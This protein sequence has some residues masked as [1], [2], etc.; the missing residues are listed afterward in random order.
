MLRTVEAMN[1][2]MA[3]LPSGTPTIFV[4]SDST[5]ETAKMLISRLLVQFEDIQPVVR[6]FG[7]VSSPERLAEVLEEASG[8]DSALV[9]ATLVDPTMVGWLG[10][11]GREKSLPIVNV[12]TPLLDQLSEFLEEEAANVPGMGGVS[13]QRIDGLVSK[14][15]FRMVE[16]TQFVQETSFGRNRIS[17]DQ[18]DFAL[19]GLRKVGKTGVAVN[20]AQRG[21][22]AACIQISKD[23]ELKKELKTFGKVVVLTMSDNELGLRRENYIL[24]LKRK[25]LPLLVEGVKSDQATIAE[26]RKYLE[27][28]VRAHPN[29]LGPIDCTQKDEA[30]IVSEILRLSR[31]AENEGSTASTSF[32]LELALVPVLAAAAAMTVMHA[33]PARRAARAPG[34]SPLPSPALAG[35]SL[36]AGLV[37]SRRS[38]G[39]HVVRSVDSD[40]RIEMEIEMRQR[41]RDEV[42]SEDPDAAVQDKT[43]YVISDSTGQTAQLLISRLLVQF[44]SLKPVVRMRANLRTR[45]QLENVVCEVSSVGGNSLI[46]ATL[47]DPLLLEQFKGIANE[48]HVKYINVMS[49]LLTSMSEFFEK[50]ARRVPGGAVVPAE[51]VDTEFFN[52]VE[53]VQYAQQ[54]LLGFNQKDWVNADAIL[55][56]MSRVGK[57]SLAFYLAQCGIKAACVDVRTDSMLQPAL[58]NVDPRKVVVLTMNANIIARRRRARVEEMSYKSMRML[59]EPG[60]ASLEKIQ[61]EQEFLKDLVKEH[62]GWLGPVDMTHLAL[63]ERA[64]MLMR[65]LRQGN[66]P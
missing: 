39:S 66:G 7:Y 41:V 57:V 4:V 14:E 63:E 11:L 22:K 21:L 61:E 8:L 16:A 44:R 6:L 32:P 40:R 25:N 47:V 46:F 54:H 42:M 55:L 34:S 33:L 27:Q 59:F 50:E 2:N 51:I 5:G 3:V 31:K 18:T 60:Y 19:V 23:R 58:A 62:P 56:G 29:W 24:E 45:E 10:R 49:P 64:S 65:L 28:V 35:S 13:Q 26:E 9:L 52:R 48:M 36:R 1:D 37:R 15:Y 38:A 43:I 30:E 53:A 20:F 12:M 17:W